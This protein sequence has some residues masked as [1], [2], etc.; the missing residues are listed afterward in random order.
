MLM[1]KGKLLLK[2]GVVVIVSVAIVDRRLIAITLL[3]LQIRFP[4]FE[5]H[6]PAFLGGHVTGVGARVTESLAA[7]G[8][9]EGFFARVNANVLLQVMFELKGLHA[10]GTFE[11]AQLVGFVVRNH[12]TLETVNIGEGFGAHFANL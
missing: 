4:H 9:F 6:H 5:I 11:L 2:P 10:L 7:V 8:A 12:V 3:P 1:M